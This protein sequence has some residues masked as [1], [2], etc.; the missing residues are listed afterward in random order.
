MVQRPPIALR[1]RGRERPH[2]RALLS[3][4][5]LFLLA[6]VPRLAAVNRYITPDE[7]VWVYRALRFREAL[8]A[9]NWAETLV[10][11]HPGVTTT[12]L[13][14]LAMSV[15]LAL[16]PGSRAA[17]DWLT[18]I[19]A[20]TP[21]NVEAYRQLAVFLTGGRLAVAIVNS[22]GVVAVYLMV[23]SLWGARAALVGGVF[24]ALD[25][26][27]VG[28]SG[29]FHVDGLSATFAIVSLLA[30]AQ[31]VTR[32]G[33]D[34]RAWIWAAVSGAAAS[35]AALTKSPML[36]L[37]P[38]SGVALL[39]PLVRRAAT[40]RQAV[41]RIVVSNC[42]VFGA[43]FF[44]A[45][46]LYPAIWV[47]PGEVLAT[48]GGS[49]NRH[50]QEALRETFFLGRV[51]YVHGPL[52][53]PVT[54]LWRLSPVVWLSLI[55]AF[56]GIRATR[57]DRRRPREAAFVTAVILLAW[58]ILFLL[59]ITPAAKKFDRYILPVVPA[60]LLLAAAVWVWWANL[61]P[62]AG[63]LALPLIV[64]AQVVYWALFATYPLGAYNPLVGGP[65][66]AVRVL[67]IGWG[68][69][70]SASGRVL[71]RT[72][73]DVAN[74]RAIAGI[75][76]SLAP[77]F[78]GETLVE[79]RDD[80]A[81][82]D[83]V[84]VTRGGR[85]LNPADV[86]DS[87]AGLSLLA[88]LRYGGLD[89]AWIFRRVTPEPPNRA[90]SLDAPVVF[91]ERLALTATD[92]RH[93]DDMVRLRLRWQR[94]RELAADERFTLRIVVRDDDGNPWAAREVDLLDEHYFFPPD[95]GAWE[96]GD[97]VY[98]LELPPGIPADTYH[99][100]LTLIDQRSA[101]QLPVRTVTEPFAGVNYE[102]GSVE[103]AP[104][105]E[106]VSA[107]RLQIPV[108]RNSLWLDGRLRLLGQGAVPPAALA[109]GRLPIDLFWHVPREKL[110]DNLQLRWYLRPASGT[111]DA[112]ITSG[113]LSR[114]DTGL[115]RTGETIQEKYLV[116]LPPDVT[117]G[118]Y[119]LLVQP[120]TT[121]GAALG[122]PVSL[123]ALRIDNINRS[124][125]LPDDAV[126]NLN[127]DFGPL[128]LVGSSPETVTARAG[129][130]VELTL[131]WENH[132]AHGEVLTVFVHLLDEG[133]NIVANADHWPGGLPTDILDSGQIVTDRFEMALPDDLPS[134]DYRVRVGIYDA[135]SGRRLP[136]V[137]SAA[138]ADAIVGQD[139]VILPT[140]IQISAP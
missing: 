120:A 136:V 114:Y 134:G 48:A 3:S 62:V 89:Q 53:Y 27:L 49:A 67:P 8:L 83:F 55:P 101:G 124:Y 9:G 74:R 75:V 90:G 13:G 138:E 106:I 115:W 131:Q 43:V 65:Y 64:G 91:G 30:L 87:T 92:I 47:A 71:A 137:A 123:G 4:I 86:D 24:L 139:D 66:T 18:R 111:A 93:F 20:L 28:L 52:F 37:L 40:E 60:L 69:G 121:D 110:P 102:V 1:D 29:L 56:L 5:I 118:H 94:Q 130:P 76:P 88:T 36:A 38:V 98:D 107:S 2:S 122:E 57:R 117:P 11:G 140:T 23:S 108:F 6:L 95:W 116:P 84:V 73:P 32:T 7:P 82:A 10:A 135:A 59:V 33:I 16:S 78:P 63:R 99:V 22:A 61:R 31:A 44:M 113:A 70:I 46:L 26:F 79:G 39:Y 127:V 17:Y 12:W 128:T 19:A 104:P 45:L 25:P 14:T 85:Q 112:S 80:P 68:E 100:E 126:A 77:F 125:S 35:L 81:T 96:T 72:E 97:I 41:L 119:D 15:Q 21:D 129:E 51:A 132:A 109:G 103:V 105:E 34:R 54:L 50:L 42:L 133:G 58:V